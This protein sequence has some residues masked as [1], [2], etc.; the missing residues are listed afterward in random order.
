MTS[1]ASLT[2]RN[3]TI[4]EQKDGI[5]QISIKGQITE[6]VDFNSLLHYNNTRLLL[7]L[8][9]I[10]RF[11]SSGIREWIHFIT[12][13]SSRNTVELHHCSSFFVYEMNMIAN[14]RGS[15]SIQSIM[16]P[17]FCSECESE[18]SFLLLLD[19]EKPSFESERP[20]LKCGQMMEVDSD[21]ETYLSFL[22]D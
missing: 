21:S 14:M 3:W 7:N 16:V 5:V 19:Q 13:L 4:E 11:N 2:N 1:T 12:D 9:G 8:E 20:C 17:Y 6:T 10:T 15:A 18:A 22:E